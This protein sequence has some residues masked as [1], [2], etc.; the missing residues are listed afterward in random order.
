MLPYQPFVSSVSHYFF[1]LK[2]QR[3]LNYFQDNYF[4]K[5]K[6]LGPK[7]K[8]MKKFNVCSHFD[9]TMTKRQNT[10]IS[11][12]EKVYCDIMTRHFLTKKLEILHKDLSYDCVC[13]QQIWFSSDK[14]ERM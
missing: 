1:G 5:L 6:F 4:I 7:F 14:G 11:E 3:N 2:K 10:H 12:T 13:P 9:V 8:F